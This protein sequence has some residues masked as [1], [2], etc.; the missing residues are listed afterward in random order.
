[1]KELVYKTIDGLHPRKKEI[2]IEETEDRLKTHITKKWVCKYFV[3][4]QHYSRTNNDVRAWLVD[5]QKEGSNVKNCHI[6]KFIDSRTGDTRILCK[7]I[8]E[9]FIVNGLNIIK[10]FYVNSLKVHM[11]RNRGT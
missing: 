9:F 1:M 7:V 4:S 3:K 6:L 8:G 11:S 2:S 10:I 5:N